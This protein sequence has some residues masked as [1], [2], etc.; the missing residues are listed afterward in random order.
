MHGSVGCYAWGG[1]YGS[2]FWVDPKQRLVGVMMI[3][4][5]SRPG[6]RIGVRFQTLA[7]SAIVR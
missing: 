1:A 6:V 3:Q 5:I 4:L 7:Y 2:T